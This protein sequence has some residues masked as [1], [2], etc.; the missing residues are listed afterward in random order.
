MAVLSNAD[1]AEVTA[2]FMRENSEAIGAMVKADL[3]G[4]VNGLDDFANTNAATINLSIP[5]P[6]R[7]VLTAAQKAR[8][9]SLV[10]RKR[11]IK[12]S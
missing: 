11:Y 3:R 4:A 7:T 10:I 2:E 6:A 12:G 8:L 9:F 1:R 5:L